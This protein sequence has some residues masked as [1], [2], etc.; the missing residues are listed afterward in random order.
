MCVML[1]Q[2]NGGENCSLWL[3]AQSESKRNKPEKLT[4]PGAFAGFPPLTLS[5]TVSSVVT[6]NDMPWHSVITRENKNQSW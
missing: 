5:D 3:E 6:H 2:K 1:K 4:T